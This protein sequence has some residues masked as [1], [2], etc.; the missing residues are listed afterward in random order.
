MICPRVHS[1]SVAAVGNESGSGAPSPDCTAPMALHLA[2]AHG[3]ID[4]PT[5]GPRSW[6]GGTHFL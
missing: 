4:L 2:A 6:G 1:H 3:M 5:C